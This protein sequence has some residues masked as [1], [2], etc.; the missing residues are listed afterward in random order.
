MLTPG[1]QLP[2]PEIPRSEKNL[3]VATRLL[4]AVF[5]KPGQSLGH[6][7]AAKAPPNLAFTPSAGWRTWRCVPCVRLSRLA[8]IAKGT[9]CAPPGFRWY[10]DV[11][12]SASSRHV[13]AVI[14]WPSA[15]ALGY[16]K[17]LLKKPREGRH[18]ASSRR[19]VAP[20][21]A[22][23]DGPRLHPRLSPWA[24]LCRP[25]GPRLTAIRHCIY[26]QRYLGIGTDP[27]A[28]LFRERALQRCRV[29]VEGV[30]FLVAVSDSC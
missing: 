11:L 10:D 22:S 3:T 29:T 12:V 19:Y 16:E 18:T 27:K 20:D 9:M 5:E 25:L 7:K 24:R 26:E 13:R 2:C 6:A 23:L 4:L 28:R 21:G 14:M 17:V 8:H 15:T 30:T 1:S